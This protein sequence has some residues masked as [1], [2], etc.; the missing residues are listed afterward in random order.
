[1]DYSYGDCEVED[2]WGMRE[3]EIVSHYCGVGL[4]GFGD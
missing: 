4:V 2:V 3:R 1:M